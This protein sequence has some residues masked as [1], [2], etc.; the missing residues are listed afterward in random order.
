M[1]LE[2]EVLGKEL[3][4]QKNNSMDVIVDSQKIHAEPGLVMGKGEVEGQELKLV[5]PVTKKGMKSAGKYALT[6]WAHSQLAEKTGIPTKYYKRMMEAQRFDLLAENV[7][8]WIHEKERRLIRILDGNVRAILSDRYRPM[9]NFDLLFAALEEF[10]QHGVDIHRCDLSETNM[11]VKVVQLHEIR[12]IKE[13]DKVVPGLVLSNSE[14]GSGGLRVEPFMLRLVCSNGLIGEQV[15]RKIHIGERK[16]AGDIW[17]DDTIRKKDE[18][19]WSEVKDVIKASFDPTI[20]NEWVE[21]LKRGTEVEVESPTTAVDSVAA[22]YNISE[23]KKND[24]LDFF[25]TQ[26]APTQWGIANAMTRMA[27]QEETAENQVELERAGNDIAILEPEE[28]LRLT[29]KKEKVENNGERA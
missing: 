24:L 4:R 26:E 9:D 28:F 21:K 3:E 12:E 25:T 2:L 23:D 27:Q 14:V 15:I 5:I 1:K 18:V 17:S 7:N 22:K 6:K 19:L 8:A 29:S 20:F 16:D 11:Y 10:K 13:D